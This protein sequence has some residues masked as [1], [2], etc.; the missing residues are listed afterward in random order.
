MSKNINFDNMIKNIIK[1]NDIEIKPS[2]D[3]FEDS[4]NMREKERNISVMKRINY[5][6][7]VAAAIFLSV[8]LG[9]I[10]AFV[11]SVRASVLTIFGIDSNGNIVE[12]SPHDKIPV[13][14]NWEAINENNKS[15]IETILGFK[16]Y[17]P[18]EVGNYKLINMVPIVMTEGVEYQDIDEVLS[19]VNNYNH[20]EAYEELSKT[21]PMHI[22][23]LAFYEDENGN[24]ITIEIYKPENKKENEDEDSIDIEGVKCKIGGGTGAKY[25]SKMVTE[26][27]GVSDITKKPE[28]V[29]TYF[30][31]WNYNELHYSI[32]DHNKVNNN[33]NRGFIKEYI[34]ILKT[35]N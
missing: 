24:E 13:S 35:K 14:T 23:I 1:D 8:I 22:S 12:K 15:E 3:I 21:Y 31:S 30:I 32:V 34:K 2:R 27:S 16:I 19:K 17:S 33:D 9:S 26:D 29:D 11:P 6:G 7:I 20:L 10:A 4:W 18:K 5:K 28:F 25:P